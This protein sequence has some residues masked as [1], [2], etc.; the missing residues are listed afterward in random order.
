MGWRFGGYRLGFM[1]SGRLPKPNAERL[2]AHS[3]PLNYTTKRCLQVLVL[4]VII[5]CG[6]PEPEPPSAAALSW[7]VL[8]P[9]QVSEIDEQM[10]KYIDR[11]HAGAVLWADDPG[12]RYETCNALERLEW[13]WDLF[14]EELALLRLQ[15]EISV[16]DSLLM[17]DLVSFLGYL[18][19]AQQPNKDAYFDSRRAGETT[20]PPMPTMGNA[21]CRHNLVKP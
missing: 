19:L 5:G 15:G 7:R 17:K 8:T 21:Y 16:E 2:T 12:I 13:D 1:A 9:A 14:D 6:Q 20:I 10:D 11:E 18:V 4:L 3:S